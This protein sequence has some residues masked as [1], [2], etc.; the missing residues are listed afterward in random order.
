MHQYG[1]PHGGPCAGPT[2]YI[3]QKMRSATDLSAVF[4]GILLLLFFG[5]VAEMTDK[6]AH[7]EWVSLRQC[8]DEHGNEIGRP[9]YV[10]V[11]EGTEGARHCAKMIK[12]TMMPGFVLVFLGILMLQG[13]H[14][15]SNKKSS[16]KLWQAVHMACQFHMFEML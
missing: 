5:K 1:G 10:D 14:F 16:R 15:G 3:K 13:A 9:Y 4:F 2:Q 11:P 7:K 8:K 12:F 6:Y